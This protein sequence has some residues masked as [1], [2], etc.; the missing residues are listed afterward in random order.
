M[1]MRTSLIAACAAVIGCVSGT[2]GAQNQTPGAYPDKPLRWLVGFPAGGVSDVLVRIVA[3]P[4]GAKLGQQVVVDN[5]PGAGGIVATQ[6]AVNAPADGYTLMLGETSTHVMKLLRKLPYDPVRDLTPVTLLAESPA[7]LVVSPALTASSVRELIELA[8]GKPDALKYASGGVGTGNH[9]IPELF[10]SM[11]GI[12]AMHVP[13]KGSPLAIIDLMSGRVDLMVSAVPPLMD[14]IRARR[15]KA[16]GVTSAKSLPSLPDVP[17]IADSVPG[18]VANTWYGAMVPSG[19]PQQVIGKLNASIVNVVADAALRE[20]LS[21]F[22]FVVS[23]STPAELARY[24]EAENEKW[25]K[26]ITEANIKLD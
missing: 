26:V 14:H 17:A 13:Y 2:A 6:L 19:A 22:G 11:T 8:K 25:A 24:I 15:V 10:K 18:F 21:G 9:L 1:A 4:L 16:L 5:R 7:V 23:T 12:R 3:Q 20:R